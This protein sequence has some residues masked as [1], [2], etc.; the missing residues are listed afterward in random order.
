MGRLAILALRVVIVLA[1]TGLLFVQGFLMPLL[2]IDLQEAGPEV[3]HLRWTLPVIGALAALCGQVALV[4][5]WRLVTMV[6]R[7]TVFSTKAFRYVDVVIGAAVAATLLAVVLSFVLAPGEAVPPG[8]V[9]LVV[10][11]GVGTA[12]IALVVFVLRMLLLQ[13]VALD[14]TATTLRAELDEVI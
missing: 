4:G 14:T 9:M 13:A 2:G 1:F 6:R 3:A 8:M 5:I 10:I 11:G 12:L 7:D